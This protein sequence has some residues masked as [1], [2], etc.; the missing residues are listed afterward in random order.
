[1]PKLAEA[2]V[3]LSLAC[4]ALP[5]VA[6]AAPPPLRLI[7]MEPEIDG[8]TSDA[9]RREEWQD[10][11]ALVADRVAD[12]LAGQALYE[13]LDPAAAEAEFA[14]HRH[15]ADVYA[16]DVCARS[17]ARAADADRVLSLRVYRMSN[18]VLSLHAIV[19]DGPSGTVRYARVLDFRGDNDRSWLKA[20]DYL[21]GDLAKLPPARR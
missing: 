3:L 15:R 19:R 1:L 21:V 13:V 8:D 16:C 20:A 14:K 18:L 5:S 2:A 6:L 9:G 11:L 4:L 7:L 17:V 12:E 10:R